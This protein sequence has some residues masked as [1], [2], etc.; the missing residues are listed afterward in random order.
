M[1]RLFAGKT[2]VETIRKVQ[3]CEIP[4]RLVEL[5]SSVD[6]ELD[7]IVLRGLAKDPKKR[8]QTGAE[9]ERELLRYLHSRYP[10]F[11][12]SNLG[13]FLK[14]ILGEKWAENQKVI[15]ETL[16]TTDFEPDI[17][18]ISAPPTSGSTG[19]ATRSKEIVL[20]ES[21]SQEI[22][23]ADQRPQSGI[24]RVHT[25]SKLRKIDT[26]IHLRPV[27]RARPSKALY[28]F[29]VAL[30]MLVAGLAFFYKDRF[31]AKGPTTISLGTRP[32]SALI[33]LDGKNIQAL[34]NPK[35]IHAINVIKIF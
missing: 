28:I 32:S 7:Q 31:L 17:G 5:N 26:K 34:Q 22:T 18:G 19:S 27:R 9:L 10:D 1:K 11:L 35:N 20:P 24:R 29:P 25:K 12:A 14:K 30:V 2:E 8:Y 13:D 3:N 4:S 33:F 23:L 6:A 16:T 15:K 21:T